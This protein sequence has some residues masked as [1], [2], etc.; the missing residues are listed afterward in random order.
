M[1]AQPE[2]GSRLCLDLGAGQNPREGFTSVD[3]CEGAAVNF[4][5]CSG[6]RWPW[7][8][9]SVDELYSS[10]F[11]EHIHAHNVC[12]YYAPG[13]PYQDA[14]LFFFDECYRIAKPGAHFTLIWPALKSSDAFRDPTHRRFIPLEMTHYL[15]CAGRKAMRIDHYAVNCNW[16]VK[17]ARMS[18]DNA[19]I[20]VW[21]SVPEV[22]EVTKHEM[23]N[24]LWMNSL[25]DVVKAYTVLL[26]KE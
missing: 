10:H 19:V 13:E 3:L 22:E 1:N 24:A 26:V 20:D 14:L 8:N 6:N 2:T 25:W 12:P 5:L 15:S 18:A 4:D 11:I 7:E 17:E 21:T 9:E 16:V 23:M